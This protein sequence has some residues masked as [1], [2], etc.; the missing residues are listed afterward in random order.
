MRHFCLLCLV[1]A[2]MGMA[3]APAGPAGAQTTSDT[4]ARL[5]LLEATLQDLLAR[6]QEK[7]RLIQ[8]LQA[9]LA[10]LRAGN[11]TPPHGA[12]GHA[13]THAHVQAPTDARSKPDGDHG[14][15]H[16]AHGADGEGGGDLF[17]VEVG[18]GVTARMKRI[19]VDV[20]LAAGYSSE[21]E[22]EV[23]EQLQGGGHDPRQNGFTVRTVDLSLIGGLDPFFDAEVHIAFFLDTEGETQVELEEAFLR[24]QTM[25]VEL[26]VGQ[27]FTEFGAFNPKHVHDWD[28]LDQP[29]VNTRM[30]GEDGI[31]GPGFRVGWTPVEQV[32]LHAGMQNAKGETMV[33]FLSS[34]E[35]F[36]ERP[37]GGRAFNERNVDSFEEFVY[38]ARLA[39]HFDV[40]GAHVDLGASGLYGPN[41]T[42]GDGETYIVGADLT[43]NAKL[44]ETRYL[45]WQSEAMYRNYD[46]DDD[47]ANGFVSDDLDDYGLYTQLLLGFSRAWAAGLRYEYVSG[48]GASVGDF[49]DRD[50]D[51]FRSDRHRISPLVQWQFAPTAKIRLQYNYD[52]ADFLEDGSD[53]HAIWLGFDWAFGAG[54]A[55]HGHDHGH[56][57]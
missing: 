11:R 53:A 52:D 24:T 1:C 14:H 42:G 56:A 44:G 7:D 38:L 2:F 43:V 41:A 18:D 27:M 9:E 54:S 10:R 6:D 55:G 32:T 34:D 15:A 51:P 12:A 40:G 36:E 20:A 3:L 37:L 30:F 26:E 57:H 50:E 4:D 19:G 35:A 25:P 17:A 45:R 23:I 46:A 29:V 33:S 21:S 28:W 47:P 48:D 8:Q 5:R 39:T 31:R 22:Q 13:D 49:D 16:S